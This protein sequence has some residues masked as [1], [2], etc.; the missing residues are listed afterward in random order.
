VT[1]YSSNFIYKEHQNKGETMGD[2]MI[3]MIEALTIWQAAREATW[4]IKTNYES[5]S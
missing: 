1:D 5:S 3:W 2:E 4:T